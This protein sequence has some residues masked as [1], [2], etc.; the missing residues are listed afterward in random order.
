MR[1]IAPGVRIED[2]PI[3]NFAISKY[4]TREANKHDMIY[5]ACATFLSVSQAAARV[6]R[7]N[8]VPLRIVAAGRLLFGRLDN[9]EIYSDLES[10]G[11]QRTR[12]DTCR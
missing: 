10:C 8:S 3:S 7:I 12:D 9:L 2:L 1:E 5:R 6:L 11:R 4:A